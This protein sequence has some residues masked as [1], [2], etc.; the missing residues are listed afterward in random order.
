MGLNTTQDHAQIAIL[1]PGLHLVQGYGAQELKVTPEE[2]HECCVFIFSSLD[3]VLV[4]T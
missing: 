2:H 3:L 1:G 4:L